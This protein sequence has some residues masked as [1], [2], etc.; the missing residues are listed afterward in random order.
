MV[1][2]VILSLSQRSRLLAP[3]TLVIGA[4]VMLFQGV[5]LFHKLALDA[6]PDPPGHADLGSHGR[7]QSPR[8]PR[9]E[10][11]RA[12]GTDPDPHRAGH[13]PLTA[14]AYFLNAVFAFSI[15]DGGKPEI[16]PAFERPEGIDGRS[17]VGAS[18]SAWVWPL[19]P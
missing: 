10:L 15:A 19:P 14:A 2:S 1:E 17:S 11:P 5:K 7:P 16:R 13:R 6:D 8:A 4:F 12:P 18:S 3:L 9:S